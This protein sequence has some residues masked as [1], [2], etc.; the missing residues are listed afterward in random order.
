[1]TGAYPRDLVG[2]G[3]NPPDP[4]WPGRARVA[5]QFV[6][7]YEEGSENCI[8]HGDEAS[9][10][11][12]TDMVG[13]PSLM[14]LKGQR[15]LMVESIYEYGS[16]AGLWRLMRIFGDRK[17][18]LTVF[19]TG[20]A[21]ERHP[22]AARAMVEAGHEL[23]SHG[24]R[25]IDY[26]GFSIEEERRHMKLA[27]E[28]QIKTT[29]TRPLGWFIGRGSMNSRKLVVEEGGFLYDSDAYADDLPW[30][31]K[32]DGKYH[33]VVPYSLDNND[34]RFSTAQGFSNG[35]QF[36][37]YLRDA[38][39]QFY[40]EGA[41]AP[42]MMSVG[43][44]ARLVGRPGRARALVKFLDHIQKHDKVW[45]CRRIDIARHWIQHHPAPKS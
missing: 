4:K 17:V 9:E 5:V 18:H 26:G 16:R 22:E 14:A 2:Y 36:F 21:L 11:I 45:I 15:S 42:K 25:W 12:L 33:L 24:Y 20:M 38:F 43:L 27:I 31:E 1:M 7:N 8:L 40:E 6:L 37:E 44:H 41:D 3:K 13:H 32:V 10:G 30:W 28:A 35:Q 23:I 39:D 19:G 29:G 34:M